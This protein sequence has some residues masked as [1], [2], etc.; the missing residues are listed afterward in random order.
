M[1]DFETSD[2]F[3]VPGM[4]EF[5]SAAPAAD[6]IDAIEVLVFKVSLDVGLNF[7]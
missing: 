1:A 2:R 7:N 4:S 6:P 3:A 5:V